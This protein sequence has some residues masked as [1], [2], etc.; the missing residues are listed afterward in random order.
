VIRLFPRLT[1]PKPGNEIIAAGLRRPKI[2]RLQIERFPSGIDG[3]H[4]DVALGPDLDKATRLYVSALLQEGLEQIWEEALTP[5]SEQVVDLFRQQVRE[6]HRVAVSQAQ[7]ASSLE[8]IQLFQIALL[9]LVLQHVDAAISKVRS[10]LDEERAL[11]ERQNHS[12]SLQL[13]RQSA[14][15]SRHGAHLRYRTAQLVLREIN[16]LEHAALRKLR[17]AVLGRSWPVAEAMLSNPM[18]PRD[19]IGALRD[20][21]DS[22]PILLYEPSV[23]VEVGRCLFAALSDWLPEELAERGRSDRKAPESPDT[24]GRREHLQIAQW[25]RQLLTEPERRDDLR[26]WVDDPDNLVALMGG[27]S[28]GWPRAGPWAP[29]DV[30]GLQR[31]L[32]GRFARLLGRAGLL[33]AVTAAYAMHAL[34]PSLGLT[35]VEAPVFDYLSGRIDRRV[36]QR[37][38]E[39]QNQGGDVERLIRRLDDGYRSYRRDARHRRGPLLARLAGDFARLRRDLKLAVPT[40]AALARIR[41]LQDPDTLQLSRAHETLQVFCPQTQQAELRGSLLGHAIVRVE[42]RGCSD[43]ALS[44]LRRGLKPATHFSRFLYD[45]LAELLPRFDAQKL[46]TEAGSL[47]LLTQQHAGEG[48]EQL[49]VAR[50][51]ALAL[52]VMRLTAAMNAEGERIGLPLL[53]CSIGLVYADSAPAYLYDQ[54]R[55]VLVS[56]ALTRARRMSS[57]H[58][59]FR[60]SC[61]L[62]AGRGVCVAA[63]LDGVVA[64]N[65]I[66]ELVRYN[67]NG[68]ELD[69]AAFIR[70]NTELAMRKVKL[71]DPQLGRPVKL[72]VG[73]CVDV[74]G[75][76]HW[77]AV[78]QQPVKLWMGR[79]VM[80]APDDEG[81]AYYELVTDRKVLQNLASKLDGR[82]DG[83]QATVRTARH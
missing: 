63:A 31:R 68:I 49:A 34:Y 62:P 52:E 48:T 29:R 10:E 5:T 1:L 53:E 54:S 38:L 74:Q 72:Y 4:V 83:Q 8:Q 67:V 71:R 43:L 55:R 75:D 3:S 37:R 25:T 11:R 82:A 69:E 7:A 13:H 79:E 78:R 59:V 33:R 18:L 6:H 57:C 61:S 9:K 28:P 56:P 64:G 14:L 40:F 26:T 47:L 73:Q 19:G 45:P 15:L 27:T 22:Y 36:L 46:S 60:R 35:D 12:R 21:K 16:R 41:L 2:P 32:N 66:G 51:C 39:A 80:D 20:F 17:H 70:I 24:P 77:I 23:A 30:S 65:G 58:T 44:M 50:G 42:I 76:L 81:R